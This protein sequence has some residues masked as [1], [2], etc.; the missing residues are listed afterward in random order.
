[1][2]KTRNLLTIA[3]VTL[4]L[5]LT[6]AAQ[7]RGHRDW[8]RGDHDGWRDNDRGHVRWVRDDDD[9][10]RKH[11]RDDRARNRRN[12]HDRDDFRRDRDER[13]TP[14]GWSKGKKTGWGNCDL[15][16]GQAKKSG[17]GNSAYYP[18]HS[19][20]YP[21]ARTVPPY[22]GAR[23]GTP[24]ISGTQV[25]RYP[26]PYDKYP[27]KTTAKRYPPPYDKYPPKK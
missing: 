24:P 15:P 21:T 25:K 9:H 20:R 13:G 4:A 7:G 6:A 22:S 16:P 23:A 26:P 5:S 12:D 19:R 18:R 2:R 3:A 11:D 10:G 27:P 17:C 14:P 1:M 8:A